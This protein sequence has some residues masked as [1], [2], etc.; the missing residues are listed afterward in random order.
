[1]EYKENYRKILLLTRKHSI[2]ICTTALKT[3]NASVSVSVTRCHSKW[4][5][6]SQNEQVWTGLQWSPPDATRRMLLGLMSRGTLPYISQGVSYHVT[7]SM[8]HS[9]LSP[10]EQTNTCENNTFPQRYWWMVTKHKYFHFQVYDLINSFASPDDGG[11]AYYKK[12][13]TGWNS[14][15][16]LCYRKWN[17]E[18]YV[19]QNCVE[20]I[21]NTGIFQGFGRIDIQ[22]ILV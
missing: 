4:V 19:Q 13:M 16:D 12:W 14:T 18:S 21:G 15:T 1:M 7:Y 6:L 17:I 20:C 22:F 5:G 11:L 2:R 8:M 3:I 10:C 9:M